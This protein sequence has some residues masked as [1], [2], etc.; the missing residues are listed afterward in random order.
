[1]RRSYKDAGVDLKAGDA[2]SAAAARVARGT[3]NERVVSAL[4]D[5]GGL[6]A[7]GTDLEDPILVSATDGVGTKVKIAFALDRHNTV[8]LDVVAMNVDDIVCQG[9]RPLFFLDYIGTGKVRPEVI[10]SI[11]AGV[12]EGCRQANCALIGGETAELPGLYNEGEYDLAGFT[13]GV[14]E[15]AKIIDGSGIREGDVVLG[16]ASSGLHSNGYSLVRQVLLEDAQMALDREVPWG[17]RSLGQELLTP[18]RIYAGVIVELLDSGS[19]IHGIAHITGGG[20]PDNIARVIPDGLCAVIQRRSIPVPPIFDL[21]QQTGNIAPDEMYRV[22]NMGAGMVLVLPPSALEPAR[23]HFSAR[24]FDNF[25]IGQIC[26]GP[27][28]RVRLVE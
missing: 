18:T 24:G 28:E 1:M 2:A 10:E 20:L 12:A 4:A 5:F 25:V 17:G 16:L 22:F 19:E 8:G 14:V 21:V 26:A 13:V 23:E 7:L 3:H 27:K 6:Y 11:V 9:A 15:R